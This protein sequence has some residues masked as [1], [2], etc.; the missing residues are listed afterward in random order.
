MRRRRLLEIYVDRGYSWRVKC[1]VRF[2][3]EV[4]TAF[5]GL[6]DTHLE[7]FDLFVPPAH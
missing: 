4:V 2:I 5:K 3:L 7:L 1:F 6:I